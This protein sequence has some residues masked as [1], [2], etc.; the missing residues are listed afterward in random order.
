[1]LSP[2]FPAVLPPTRGGTGLSTY[3]TGDILQASGT[4]TLAKLAAVAT[5][6]VFLSGGVAT[7]GSWGKVG[8]TTHVS[9]I[10]P[11]ANGGTGVNNTGT[12]TNASNTTIT[13]GGTLAL[14]GFSLTVPA[15]GTTALLATANTFTQTNAFQTITATNLQLSAVGIIYAGGT[16]ADQL[17]CYFDTTNSYWRAP[18]SGHVWQSSTGMTNMT[19]SE[20]GLLTTPSLVLGTDPGGSE[21]LRVGGNSKI[22]GLIEWGNGTIRGSATYGSYPLIGSL[23]S[24][25]FGFI[26]GGTTRGY[27]DIA[28]ALIIG[29]D[30]GGSQLFRAGGTGLFSGLLTTATPT[31][32]TAS[33]NLPH[34][35]APTTPAN[36]DMWTTTAGL[37][38]HVNGSTIGPL[39]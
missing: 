2:T 39:S 20:G 22:N 27:F 26:T 33:I 7:I 30:P 14:G 11:A 35:T 19:L 15:T 17:R 16:A 32:S 4:T 31:T 12:I 29:T 9:G 13:G 34:G 23:S 21:L 25:N 8:L 10:L 24:H 28:G 37:Y 38:V 18:A 5:G 36:G 3:T 6:N 1:M